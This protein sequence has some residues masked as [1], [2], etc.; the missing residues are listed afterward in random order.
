MLSENIATLLCE[1]Y[2]RDK[3]MKCHDKGTTNA[4]K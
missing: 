3:K 2:A 4:A 1:V